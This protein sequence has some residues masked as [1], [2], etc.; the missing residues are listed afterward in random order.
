MGAGGSP[1]VASAEED[2]AQNPNAGEGHSWG[3]E[4]TMQPY[5]SASA[6]FRGHSC[7]GCGAML[8]ITVRAYGR[9]RKKKERIYTLQGAVVCP[10]GAGR[11]SY[12][13]AQE[14]REDKGDHICVPSIDANLDSGEQARHTEE[15]FVEERENGD[16]EGDDGGGWQ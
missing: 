10:S 16:Q 8:A 11:Q 7:L 6:S 9:A 15:Q 1:T 5:A 3:P 12:G 14:Y 4:A 2:L 13:G